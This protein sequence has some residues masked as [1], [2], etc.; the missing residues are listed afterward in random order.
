M[1]K[2]VKIKTA[3][4]G[5]GAMACLFAAR[6][7]NVADVVMVGHWPEQVAA[8][9]QQGLTLL[10]QDGQQHI[11]ALTITDQPNAVPPVDLA[12][13]LV[14]SWQSARTAQ[15]TAVLLKPTGTAVTLQ[16]G[17]GNLDP[18]VE[19]IGAERALAGTTVQAA[20]VI[21][22]GIVAHAGSGLTMLPNLPRAEIAAHLLHRAGLAVQLADNVASVLWGKL[23]I[24]AAINPLAAL[25][26]IPNGELLMQQWVVAMMEKAANEVTAV[27][28]AQGIHL[29]FANAAEQAKKVAAAT[30]AN[31]ASMR[32][33][34]ARGGSTEIEAICGAVV[35]YGRLHRIP[36]PVNARL[37]AW[38]RQLEQ[39]G[40]RPSLAEMR[41]VV[42]K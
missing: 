32:Q 3:V 7:A 1:G 11:Y 27:A 42:D 4:M 26:D 36:T 13:V 25:L 12:F 10:E 5:S 40:K 14:K 9:Q 37:Y 34:V 22:P 2:G 35:K 20:N 29:P 28:R 31:S 23:A 33:D 30:A 15:E 8:I 38:V 21:A 6:L 16:N 19:A 39:T 17:L 41:Q 24:N 18:L